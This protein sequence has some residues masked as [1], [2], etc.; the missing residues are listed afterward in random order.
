MNPSL[1]LGDEAINSV[2]I[3]LESVRERALSMYLSSM[4][5]SLNC[6][7]ACRACIYA[8]HGE[9]ARI[10]ELQHALRQLSYFDLFGRSRLTIQ[11]T[12]IAIMLPIA[13]DRA[14]GGTALL[15]RHLTLVIHTV[16]QVLGKIEGILKR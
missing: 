9:L 3:S 2:L 11:L 4:H 5:K 6:C 16:D 13:L 7:V 8:L 10:I 1:S 14:A 15:P 12:R